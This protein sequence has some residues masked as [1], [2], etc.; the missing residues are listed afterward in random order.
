MFN[1]ILMCLLLYQA[2]LQ[3]LNDG[4]LC[5]PSLL[6]LCLI[7]RTLSAQAVTCL[8]VFYFPVGTTPYHS[9]LPILIHPFLSVI[10][11]LLLSIIQSFL[12]PD[13]LYRVFFSII[14]PPLSSVLLYRPTFS[15]VQP[16][17]SQ[18]SRLF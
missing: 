1:G 5:S 12:L 8:P 16:S 4:H 11:Y 9:L 13:L 3:H 7:Y 15:I 17:P 14:Y 10:Y 6:T 2:F 18:H